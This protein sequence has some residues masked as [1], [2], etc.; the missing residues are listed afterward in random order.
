IRSAHPA[1]ALPI[2]MAT[3]RDQ[4]ED[5]VQALQQGANDY[6]TKPIDFPVVQAR[7]ET[8]LAL[9]R[10]VDEIVALK[11]DLEQRNGDLHAANERMKRD[12]ESAARVQRSLLPSAAPAVAEAEF[13]WIFRPCDLLG[14]DILNVFPIGDT[15]VGLYVLDVSGHGVPAALLSV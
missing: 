7:I 13:S 12:L 11:R 15:H 9:K 5:V 14:G 2:I 4:R 6:V 3:A 8:Q 10:A 1:T